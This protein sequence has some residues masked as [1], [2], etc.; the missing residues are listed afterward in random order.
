MQFAFVMGYLIGTLDIGGSLRQGNGIIDCIKQYRS[1]RQR[2][3]KAIRNERWGAV[4]GIS[5]LRPT[6]NLAGAEE[7]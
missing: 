4:A 6:S 1:P 5:K 2:K 3:K 7:E